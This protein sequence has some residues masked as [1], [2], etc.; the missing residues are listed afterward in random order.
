[1]TIMLAGLDTSSALGFIAHLATH[2]N[3]R[4]LLIEHPSGFLTPSRSSA[5]LRRVPGR[6]ASPRTSTSMAAR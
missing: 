3:D 4:L 6:A 1:M 5:G 2:D